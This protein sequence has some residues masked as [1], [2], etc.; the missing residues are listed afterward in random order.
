MDSP[1]M[2]L[3]AIVS[4][5]SEDRIRKIANF[6]GRHFDTVAG[7]D[8]LI[9]NLD[10]VVIATPPGPRAAIVEHFL[11]RDVPV[12]AEKPLTLDANDTR[13]LLSLAQSRGVPLIE[14][15]VHLY[16]WPYREIYAHAREG[17]FDIQSCGGNDGPVR[18]FSPLYDYGPHDV[19]MALRAIGR[20]PRT[21]R[22]SIFDVRSIGQYCI[23]AEMDFADAGVA[24]I[25]FGNGFAGK[26]R[27][28]ELDDNRDVWRYDDLAAAPLLVNGRRRSSPAKVTLA[29][30]AALDSFIGYDVVVTPA[31]S[32]WLSITTAQVLDE[33]SSI[34]EPLLAA[35]AGQSESSK[36]G[37][38]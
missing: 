25:S 9:S 13:R 28:F 17:R 1:R 18:A 33:I 27:Y 34:T 16:A 4:S 24:A 35:H 38:D 7:L 29:L 11:K 37:C 22:A 10:G 5:K 6:S 23:K 32:A 30:E 15:F 8:T 3:A 12:F 31:E 14:D 26:H 21:V 36:P 2:E 19:S 20:S